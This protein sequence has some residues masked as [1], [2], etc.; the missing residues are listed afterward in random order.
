MPCGT[1]SST[2]QRSCSLPPRGLPVRE[3][4]CLPALIAAAHESRRG[5]QPEFPHRGVEIPP[6][7]D[8][9]P[10]RPAATADWHLF[11]YGP[12]YRVEPVQFQRRA[13][14]R[15]AAGAFARRA[16]MLKHVARVGD[17]HRAVLPDQLVTPR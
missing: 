11:E 2:K 7:P 17:T 10:G 5:E 1:G 14:A 4:H 12:G 8:R 13:A 15:A 9:N 3:P 6:G 16:E